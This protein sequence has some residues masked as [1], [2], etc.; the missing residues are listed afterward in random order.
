VNE[1]AGT[2][3]L[4]H[5]DWKERR[6]SIAWVIDRANRDVSCTIVFLLGDN[7]RALTEQRVERVHDLNFTPQIPGIMR[8]LPMPAARRSRTP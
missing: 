4:D 3:F 2:V 1:I 7:N 5:L 6:C 8:S